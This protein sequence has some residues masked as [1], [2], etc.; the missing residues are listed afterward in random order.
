M[1]K[2][3]IVRLTDEERPTLHRVM[4]QLQ[5]S[6]EQ[7][8]RAP[9][10]LKADAHGPTWT[11]Q[12][13]AEAFWCRTKT[14]ENVRQRLVTVGFE[15][16]LHRENPQTPPRQ[17]QLEGEQ[18]AQGLALRL[19]KPPKGCAHGSWRLLAEQ[20]V[21]LAIAATVSHETLRKRLKKPVCPRARCSPG[22]SRRPPT[23]HWSRAGTT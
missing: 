9:L 21:E 11:D 19:G 2:K 17:Q 4:K 15:R 14:G 13:I 1:E 5:G 8:R 22:S 7:V 16:A 18:E 6:S 12:K 10:L 23:A 3:S 20:V